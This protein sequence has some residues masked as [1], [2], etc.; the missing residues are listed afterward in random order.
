MIYADHRSWEV[1]LFLDRGVLSKLVFVVG[2]FWLFAHTPRP[3]TT[4][5]PTPTHPR[6]PN[7]PNFLG[8][9]SP[10]PPF[11]YFTQ[12][13]T[14]GYTRPK[15]LK[16]LTFLILNFAQIN[17]PKHPKHTP[18]NKFPEKKTIFFYPLTY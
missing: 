10:L 4:P 8:I 11:F 2:F 9:L 18:K 13:K 7:A 12:T 17:T 5:P 1:D 14:K 16:Y 3:H 15:F 6:T